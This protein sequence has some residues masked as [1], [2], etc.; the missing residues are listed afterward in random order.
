MDSPS[1]AGRR[2]LLMMLVLLGACAAAWAQTPIVDRLSAE[3]AAREERIRQISAQLDAGEVPDAALESDLRTLIEYQDRFESNAQTLGAALEVPTVSLAELGPPPDKDSPPESKD[4]ATLRKS[5]NGAISRLTGLVKQSEIDRANVERLIRRIRELQGAR[6]LSRLGT[7]SAS[8]FSSEF[9]TDAAAEVPPMLGAFGDHARAWWQHQRESGRWR[10]D[11]ALLAAA[12][13]GAVAILMSPRWSRWRAFEAAR[14]AIPAPSAI[15]KR[16]RVAFMA[17]SR[18]VLAAAAA[19][20]LYMAGTEVGLIGEA[21]QVLALRIWIGFTAVVLVWNFA[22]SAFSPRDERWRTTGVGSTAAWAQCWLGVGIYC[23]FVADRVLAAGFELAGAG[24]QFSLAMG[25][26]SS[27][28]SMVLLLLFIGLVPRPSVI[29]DQESDAASPTAVAPPKLERPWRELLLSAGRVLA[30]LILAAIALAYVALASFV[31]HRLLLL[32][33]FL[34]VFY[35]VRV[36]TLWA[37]SGLP[38]V[39]ATPADTTERDQEKQRLGLWLRVAVDVA[40]LALGIP[41]LLLTVGYGWLDLQS[42]LGVLTAGVRIGA[43]SLSLGNILVAILVF[44]AI[45][46][47]TRWITSIADTKILAHAHLD[48]GERN[49]IVVLIKYAGIVV[50][51]LVAFAIAG[52]SVTK[53]MI[54]AGGLSVGIGLGLQG[55]VNNFVSGLILLFERP[56]KIGDWVELSAGQGYV[57]HIGPR[58]TEIE[59]FDQ[60]SIIIPNADL[61]TSPVQNWFHKNRTGRVRVAVGVGYGSDPEQVRKILLDCAAKNESVMTFPEPQVRW[62]DFGDS[63]LDFE[64]RA[65]IGNYDRALVVRSDLRFAIF[66]ALK[67]AGIELP[68]P[69]RDLHIRSDDTKGDRPPA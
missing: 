44:L 56:I 2:I 68:F 34:I 37:L 65:Y 43:I 42:W 61:V 6:F 60:A 31:F 3:Y 33:L 41:A 21:E 20:L 7:R 32:G 51:F 57:K 11:L 50:A 26:V 69:Q 35:S 12:L 48:E 55:V 64:L 29:H 36:L 62:M 16:R 9:W 8:P 46:V 53:L 23:L 40:L 22:R 30:T 28:L 13:A 52:V 18:G 58:A 63:S 66:R 45:S 17:L 27:G 54:V 39:A 38:F 1:L 49:S 24:P 19:A 25:A 67:D 4:V 15:Q 10:A 59:T 5:L 47:G 14:H